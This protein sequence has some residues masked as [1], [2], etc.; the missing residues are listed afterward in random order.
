MQI[1]SVAL[2]M[3][4]GD[5]LAEGIKYVSACMADCI[6]RNEIAFPPPELYARA[7]PLDS[8]SSEM[9]AQGVSAARQWN[10][11]ADATVVYTDLGFSTVV[12]AGIDRAKAYRRPI[13]Y[14]SL[15]DWN[16]AS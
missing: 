4:L 7:L 9:F 1:R 3:S 12:R 10:E 8:S 16:A 2:E 15:P 14:R 6:A 5:D 13:E 11:H